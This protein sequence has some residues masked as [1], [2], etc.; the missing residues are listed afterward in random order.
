MLT[1]LSETPS[2]APLQR[3][4]DSLF[5]PTP[6]NFL[7]LLICCSLTALSSIFFLAPHTHRPILFSFLF[8]LILVTGGLTLSFLRTPRIYRF[9]SSPYFAILC[10]AFIGIFGELHYRTRI[11]PRPEF[12]TA[13]P[14]LV[15]PAQRLFH[16]LDPYS[17]P[18]A[19]GAL[20]SPG[21]G[22][23]LLL[24]PLTLLHGAGL[25]NALGLLAVVLLLGQRD[26]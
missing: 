20:I 15:Q 18:L 5:T 4:P 2:S 17:L 1:G 10:L 24:A 21:P 12:L 3:G 6:L 7:L 22:W 8:F 11:E 23:I 25:L 13:A 26:L 9:F 14:A 19:H 16:G